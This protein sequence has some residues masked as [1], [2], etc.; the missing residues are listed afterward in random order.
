MKDR[1]AERALIAGRFRLERCLGRGGMGEVWAATHEVTGKRCAL[2]FLHASAASSETRFERFAREARAACTID[3]PGVID[4]HDV[5]TLDD[6]APVM[7]MELLE[8]ETLADK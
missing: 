6:G 2:K 1:P 3:H 5:F 8:G 4:V 7:V